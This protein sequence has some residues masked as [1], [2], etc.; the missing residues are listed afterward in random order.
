MRTLKHAIAGASTL[1]GEVIDIDEWARETG[2]PKRGSNGVLSGAAIKRILGIE[3]KSWDP[4]LFRN[5]ESITET[6]ER[7]LDDARMAPGEL[8]AAILVTC[9][10]YQTHLNQDAFRLLKE[11]KLPDSIVPIQ[12][13]AGCAGMAR[14]MAIVSQLNAENVLVVTYNLPSLYMVDERGQQN[15]QYLKNEAHPMGGLL[16]TSPAI[17]SDAVASIVL[18]KDEAMDGVS[19][20]SRDSLSFGDEPGFQDPL[21]HYLGG[22]ALHPPGFGQSEELACYGMAGEPVK[23]YYKK[24]M[25]LNHRELLC[26]RPDYTETVRRIYTHQA[27]PRLVN[28]FLEQST[29]PMCKVRTNV[30]EYG[31]TVT[32]STLKLLHDDIRAGAVKPGDDI[33][34]SVVG[35]GPERGAF[36]TSVR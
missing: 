31:N 18:R 12:I 14:A 30:E 3:S 16:W 9:T 1:V 23:K 34:I 26:E 13:G 32:P 4:D 22:G 2:I 11:M 8:D 17:F 35:A 29:L 7:A 10:P 19:F 6:T 24:G 20:Y 28:G 36:I 21:I 15:P 33:C 27:S 5:F 25:M